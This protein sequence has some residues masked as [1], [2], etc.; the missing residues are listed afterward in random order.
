MSTLSLKKLQKTISKILTDYHN[1]LNSLQSAES[2]RKSVGF[3]IDKLSKYE[4][5]N[6]N[7]GA[8]SICVAPKCASIIDLCLIYNTEYGR[9]RYVLTVRPDYKNKYVI[10]KN[11]LY[12]HQDDIP[13]PDTTVRVSYELLTNKEG[14]L[15]PKSKS[16]PKKKAPAKEVILCPTRDTSCCY[17]NKNHPDKCSNCCRD[18]DHIKCSA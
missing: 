2:F 11:K 12:L 9:G 8:R 3:Q 7:Y 10:Y 13:E 4:V 15:G 17:L 1:Y 18:R 5:D 14:V 6:A 16:E